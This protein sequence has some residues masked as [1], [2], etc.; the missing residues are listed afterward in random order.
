MSWWRESA[1]VA[2]VLALTACGFQLRGQ[3]SLPD[4][5][6]PVHIQAD[7]GS[8]VAGEL[9]KIL[10]RNNVEVVSERT[11]AASEI[12]IVDERRERR[13]LSV[14]ATSAD[15]D[16]FELRYTTRWLLRDTDDKRTALTNLQTL[17]TLRD[18]TYDKSAVLAKQSEEADLVKEMQED[19]ALQIL[20]RLQAWKPAQ[21]PEPADVEAQ[22]EIQRGD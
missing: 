4:E 7:R 13:V 11:A 5:L 10:R 1:L 6:S 19:T 3:F 22:L 17:E 9:R 16:E 21:V 12:E 2:V 20:Y 14:S 8:D 18:Y 15:V